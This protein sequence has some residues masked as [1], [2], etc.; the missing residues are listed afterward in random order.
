MDLVYKQ[1]AL[2]QECYDCLINL[3]NS[4]SDTLE[5]RRVLNKLNECNYSF[6]F[7]SSR[8]RGS[9]AIFV[10]IRTF[11][12]HKDHISWD[13]ESLKYAGKVMGGKRLNGTTFFLSLA[14]SHFEPWRVLAATSLHESSCNQN[15][16]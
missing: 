12:Q 11:T 5:I 15:V 3:H 16:I 2:L 14:S 1:Q 4:D 9:L 13:L 6:Q 7:V 8:V 10:V